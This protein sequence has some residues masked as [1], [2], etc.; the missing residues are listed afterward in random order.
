MS[1]NNVN[2]NYYKLSQFYEQ[3]SELD[4]KMKVNL[5]NTLIPPPISSIDKNTNRVRLYVME[6]NADFSCNDVTPCSI[7][8]PVWVNHDMDL[9]QVQLDKPLLSI[10]DINWGNIHFRRQG[11]CVLTSLIN[12]I[13]GYGSTSNSS[14]SLV[15]LVLRW[16]EI[17]N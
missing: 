5:F 7:Q 11:N 14:F 9:H 2:V 13:D 12:A 10:D 17:K 1:C 4:L 6:I 8:D 16:S 3:R 15:K